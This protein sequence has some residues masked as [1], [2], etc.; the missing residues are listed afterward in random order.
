MPA[1]DAELLIMAFAVLL[2]FGLF[3]APFVW[4]V[5]WMIR[6]ANPPG[7][8]KGR[9]CRRCGYPDQGLTVR[10]C[11]ECGADYPQRLG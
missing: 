9:L 7:Y 11:P 10:R 8:G 1:I 4:L 5:R 6:R 3:C 2:G